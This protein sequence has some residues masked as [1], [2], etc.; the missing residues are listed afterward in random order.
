MLGDS[1]CG[2]RGHRQECLCYLRARH[3]AI[4]RIRRDR[5]LETKSDE[6]SRSARCVW[7]S[8]TPSSKMTRAIWFPMTGC[9]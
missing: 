8:R 7:S 1:R 4:D 6:I 2:Q 9:D 5:R 3:K